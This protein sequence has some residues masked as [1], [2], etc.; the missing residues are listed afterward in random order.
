[1]GEIVAAMATCH[2]PQL[3]TYPPDEDP[4]QL[5]ASIAGMHELGKLLDE[6]KP[7]VIIFLGSDHLETFSIGCV[8]TFA[9]VAGN[10]AIAEFAG[11]SY[12]LPI[13]REMAEDLLYKLVGADFDVAY[14][15]DAVL[16]HTFAVPFEFVIGGRDIP[17]IPIHTNVYL[18]PLPSPKR[19]AALG[20]ALANVIASRPER[21]AIIASGGMSHYPGTWKYPQ[22]EFEFDRWVIQEL[23]KGNADAVLDLTTEQLDAAG[24]T[25]LL[26]WAVLLGAIGK[27]PGELVQYTP[28]WH[29]GHA[30]MRFLPARE[31]AA[32]ATAGELPKYGGLEFKEGGFEFYK[33]PPAEAYQLN[34]LLFDMRH[35]GALRRRLLTEFGGVTAEYKLPDACLDAARALAEVGSTAKVSDNA[36]RIVAAGA[37]PLHALMTLHAVHGEMKRLRRELT[38]QS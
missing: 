3:F 11:R 37:H 20:R 31:K 38:N 21:M 23:E 10:R 26:P 7:D 1:M 4:A 36:G 34:K 9:I 35:D 2:A 27:A 14:S 13:H 33:H 6:T 8:P 25:E 30:M 16:G 29:H 22:P 28:T 5:D 19:C 15:E 32:A 17:V 12:D 24:N 18:P